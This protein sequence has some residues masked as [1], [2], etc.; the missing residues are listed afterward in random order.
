M[1]QRIKFLPKLFGTL[2]RLGFQRTRVLHA[3]AKFLIDGL[4]TCRCLC[5]A[6]GQPVA[7]RLGGG[8]SATQVLGC[9]LR[10]IHQCLTTR[11]EF[12]GAVRGFGG[13]GFGLMG[14]QFQMQRTLSGFHG[15]TKS[16][17]GV[18]TLLHAPGLLLGD[19]AMALQ[20]ALGRDGVLLQSLRIGFGGCRE[21]LEFLTAAMS[22]LALATHLGFAA[23]GGLQRLL[24]VV[25]GALCGPRGLALTIQSLIGG[26]HGVTIATCASF[27]F[28]R[29]HALPI[30]H[31][32]RLLFALALALQS[33]ERALQL[34]S[35]HGGLIVGLARGLHHGIAATHRLGGGF[36]LTIHVLLQR[37]FLI[38]GRFRLRTGLLG[39]GTLGLELRQ[40]L[41]CRVALHIG[42]L[43]RLLCECL[44][45][46]GSAKRVLG[47]RAR[48]VGAA[49][50]L[51]GVRALRFGACLRFR[52]RAS[53]ALQPIHERLHHATFEQRLLAG[54]LGGHAKTLGAFIGLSRGGMRTLGAR[55]GLLGQL[56]RGRATAFG[57]VRARLFLTQA[58]LGVVG[59]QTFGFAHGQQA[60]HF[61][62]RLDGCIAA[63]LRGLRASRKFGFGL[64]GLTGQRIGVLPRFGCTG[65]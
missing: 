30:H 15:L 31:G 62:G 4:S 14:F 46:L 20:I 61:L 53:L 48:G 18:G 47:I 19:A 44:L 57:L 23:F 41:H 56:L 1:L 32:A 17:A 49:K 34:G 25:H 12:L 3:R 11:G 35:G 39:G 37:A 36:A 8:A 59:G 58:T 60:L 29:R 7:L 27:G 50:C 24:R 21:L 22:V 33:L 45:R 63:H 38:H 42:A 40:R 9:G 26:Q 55:H 5:L 64:H 13:H 6:S 28:Q 43:Q 16:L 52:D 10:L 54:L 2:A 65:A 51:V